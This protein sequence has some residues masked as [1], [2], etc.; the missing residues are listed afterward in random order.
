MVSVP[1][2]PPTPPGAS[3]PPLAT[4]TFPPI[5]PVPPS[6]A[7]PATL[8]APVAADWSPLTNSAPADTVVTPP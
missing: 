8:V 4:L 7:P 6:V 1:T 5:V 2:P 3:V